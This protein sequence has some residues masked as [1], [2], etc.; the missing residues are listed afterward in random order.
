MNTT[1][2]NTPAKNRKNKKAGYNKR[3]VLVRFIWVAAFLLC[4]SAFIVKCSF[5][6]SI[7]NADKWND[8]AMKAL[9]KVEIVHPDRGKILA[10]D[11]TVLATTLKHYTLRID[12]QSE[13]F[14]TDTFYAKIDTIC[15]S[16]AH[17]YP[18]K[19]K[20]EWKNYLTEPLTR[21]KKPRAHRLVKDISYADYQKICSWPF[22]KIKNS[23]RNGLVVESRMLRCYPYGSMARRSIG[24]VNEDS[25]TGEVHGY[26]GLECAL[27]P[28][29]YGKKGVTKKVPLTK[30]IVDIPDT[31]AV[32]GLNVLSTIDITIQDIVESELGAMLQKCGADW[33]T[34]VL[35]RVSTGD[36][37][38]ISNLDHDTKTGKLKEGMNRAVLG[39]EPGSVIKTVSM[40]IAL[41]DKLVRDTSQ[42]IITGPAY[43]YAGGRAITDSHGVA[44]M[45]ISEV[46]ERS[47]N[48]GMTKIMEMGYRNC[49]SQFYPRLE[50]AGFFDK[51]NS[52]IAGEQIPHYPK[53]KDGKG[54]SI[55]FSRQTYGYNTEVPPLSLLAWYNALANGGRYVRPRL[56]KGFTGNGI[57]STIPVSYIRER[58]CS[59]ENA[60][61]MRAML[62]KVVN[63]K[64]GTGRLLKN[65]KVK[66]A[67]KT[68]TCYIV[69]GRHYNQSK[70]RVSFVGFYPADNPIYSC[71]VVVSNPKNPRGAASVSGT[72]LKEI[73]LK[74]YARGLLDNVSDYRV[75]VDPN[76]EK[77]PTLYATYKPSRQSEMLEDLSMVKPRRFATPKNDTV[78][79]IPN[80]VGLGLRE[81]VAVLEN[82]G[83]NVIVS[84]AGYVREQNPKSGTPLILDSKVTLTLNE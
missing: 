63:G 82:A 52:G 26:S 21:E 11:G 50:R 1:K 64:H 81:A 67:G 76:S 77:V 31:P 10:S 55:A 40:T 28:W 74:L 17:Y 22:F 8:L 62:S 71:A 54:G 19:T 36:I 16:L 75:S 12:Y 49:P 24:R 34:A 45:K 7:T 6:T 15:D 80:V 35:M 39:Y 38:A 48:I 84:G 44:S 42:V 30:N 56:V 73:A 53:V 78:G 68:G 66:I 79:T 2:D 13:K 72:V 59:E 4:F 20:N 29:L 65:N 33:G 51:I 25:A 43:N 37:V 5:D 60:A 9:S 46:L 69:E 58:V 32:A 18:Y 14:M 3:R 41:E 57:D 47:S 27:D 83:I 70:R 61:I 23:N